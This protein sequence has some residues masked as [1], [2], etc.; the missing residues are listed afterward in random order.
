[1]E[2][3]WLA[4]AAGLFGTLA[5]ALVRNTVLVRAWQ[6]AGVIDTGTPA[7]VVIYAAVAS[8]AGSLAASQLISDVGPMPAPV[9]GMLAGLLSAGLMGLLMVTYRMPPGRG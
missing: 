1:M 4:I 5:A 7:A 2:L 3:P 6:A 8:L 9:T